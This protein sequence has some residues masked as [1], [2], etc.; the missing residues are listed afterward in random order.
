MAARTALITGASRGI[1]REVARTLAGDGWHVLSGVRD[2]KTA[3]PGTQAETVDMADPE[4]ID[5]LCKR[6]RARNQRLDA[7]VNN[8]A[9]YHATARHIW[10]VNVLGPLLL[11]AALEP[12]LARNARVVMVTSRLGLLSAQPASLV[13]RL[14]NP[15]LSLAELESLAKG[16]PGGYGAS[17]AALAAM[18]RLFADK[19]GPRGILV[20]AISPGWVRTDM[21]GPS[22]PRSVEQ[23]AASILWGVRL[24]PGGP[25]GGVFEDGKA[26]A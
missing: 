8:A 23:G 11:T 21:G 15:D 17:K 14:S 3:P 1:G 19:L 13:K 7:L 2:P 12:L 4:S 18:A 22:A 24:P 6:L 9:V 26:V 10:D 5:A 16:A 25:S 20:N